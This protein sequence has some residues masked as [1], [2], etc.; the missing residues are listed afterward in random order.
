MGLIPVKP[1]T[2]GFT[3]H[4]DLSQFFFLKISVM[5]IGYHEKK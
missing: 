4:K 2:K 5:P 3:E 1:A